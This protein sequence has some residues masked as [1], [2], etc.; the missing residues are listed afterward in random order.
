VRPIS[1]EVQGLTSYREPVCIDFT[2]LDLFAIT[3]PTGSGKSSLVDAITYALFGQVPRVGRGIKDLISQGAARVHVKLEFSADGKRYRVHRSSALKGASPIQLEVFDESEDDWIGLADKATD[4][5]AQIEE[6]LRLDYEA[7]IRSV[8]L[9]QG[10]FQEFLAGDRDQRRKVLDR[11]LR[12]GVYTEMQKRANILAAKEREE[13][14]R[15]RERLEKELSGATPEALAAAQDELARL[16]EEAVELAEKRKALEEASRIA[17]KL[18]AALARA[19]REQRAS[20]QA[21]VALDEARQTLVGGEKVTAELDARLTELR[22]QAKANQYD[23]DLH[24]KLT[25]ALA[26]ARERDGIDQRI[27]T[28]AGDGAGARAELER[29]QAAVAEAR[30]QIEVAADASELASKAFEAVQKANAAAVLRARLSPGDPCPVCGKPVGELPPSEPG[31]LNRARSELERARTDEKKA[32]KAASDIAQQAAVLQ[33][34]QTKLESQLGDLKADRER[35][36]AQLK[37]AIG[38]GEAAADELRAHAADLETARQLGESLGREERDLAEQRQKA[39]Q[40]LAAAGAGVATL[41]AQ[42]ATHKRENEA[43]AR[44]AAEARASINALATANQWENAVEALAAELDVVP[45]VRRSFQDVQ[46]REAVVNQGI[47]ASGKNIEQIERNIA[48]AEELREKEK[49]HNVAARLAKDLGTILRADGLPAFVRDSAM[50]ALAAGGS[51][52][53][54][55][56]SGG[57][58]DLKVKGQDFCVADLWNAGEERPV[59]TLSGGETFLA[60]LALALALAEQLPGM[61]GEGETSTLESLFIDEGFSHL[62]EETLKVV[63]DALE[64]LGA[65]RRRLIGVITHLNALAERLP[66]RIIV[67]KDSAGGP[68]TVTIE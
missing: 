4:V 62:D 67:R 16:Q 18:V 1:L 49:E 60:S 27:V 56:V 65:D 39:A 53:L 8:L 41:E 35:R 25:G 19:D 43:A 42:V 13:A 57:R 52:W 14:E 29:I 37:V 15:I 50:Q 17:E 11:L 33:E 10:E 45:V 12:L 48:L 59:Q 23:A 68:S 40:D 5:T 38:D 20:E 66:A 2:D 46:E 31:D 34:R 22:E 54:R 47:G 28:L 24:V 7:F 3:G 55:R 32:E 44:E 61:S 9:P 30:K 64:V 6:L 21:T 26:D 36:V 58:Y 63:A 51:S